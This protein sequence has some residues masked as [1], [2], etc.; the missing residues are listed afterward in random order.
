MKIVF[1]Q[2]ITDETDSIVSE[3]YYS[4]GWG[5]LGIFGSLDRIVGRSFIWCS[6]EPFVLPDVSDLGLPAPHKL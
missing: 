2:P 5:M 6:E 3:R 1:Y 4:L